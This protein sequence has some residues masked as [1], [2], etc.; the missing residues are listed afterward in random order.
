MKY[1]MIIIMFLMAFNIS[2]ADMPAY[3]IFDIEGDEVDYEDMTETAFEADI[4]FFG[5]LHNNPICH[6]LQLEL[7][8][9]MHDEV[10][11]ML[12]L[13]AEMFESDNQLI[14]DEYLTG[15]IPQ[16]N[17]EKEV[18][19]WNNY[20]TDYKPL[21]EFA[22]E[23]DLRFIATNIPRRYAAHV[24]RN[25]LEKLS[26]F[27][28]EAQKFFPP[29]PIEVDLNLKCYAA[30]EDMMGGMHASTK[31]DSKPGSMDEINEKMKDLTP[32]E[33]QEKMNKM[34]EA[35]KKIQYF[36]EAQAVKDAT[37]AHFIL[38]NMSQ[39]KK[40]LH[41]NG[42]YHSDNHESIVWFIKRDAPQYKIITI[43]SVSQSD[44]EEIDEKHLGLADFILVIPD[45]MTTTY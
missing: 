2:I 31:K 25:G 29:L 45:N 34:M 10:G 7:T 23:N 16:S 18:R 24:A 11:D 27:S 44:L 8:K 28:D 39:G 9:S 26:D 19:L 36:K 17:F 33:R 14:V 43:A 35:M 42:T 1:F 4:V 32:E 5:E 15:K 6:W 37:M 3:K 30:M 21:M 13:G 38:E 12:V 40:F 20:Q 22:K 41:Y